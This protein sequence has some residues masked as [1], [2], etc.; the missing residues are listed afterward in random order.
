M[1]S[2]VSGWSAGAPPSPGG[3]AADGPAAAALPL[4]PRTG[5]TR[6]TSAAAGS[7]HG[8]ASLWLDRSVFILFTSWQ[9]LVVLRG[10]GSAAGP[11]AVLL[12]ELASLAILFGASKAYWRNRRVEGAG[13][14]GSATGCSRGGL[15]AGSGFPG[16]CGFH[17]PAA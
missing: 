2:G 5:T 17:T 10:R 9:A 11:I 8:G 6:P 14:E 7:T 16:K 12:L 15:P 3:P 4:A 13:A 1:N